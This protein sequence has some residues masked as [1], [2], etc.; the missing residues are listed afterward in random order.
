MQLKDVNWTVFG[1]SIGCAFVLAVLYAALVRWT[2]RRGMEGQTAWA[3]VI[4]VTFTLLAMIPFFG[5][6]AV[7]F[8]FCYFIATGIPMIV[9]YLQRVQAEMQEDKKQANQIAK[10]FLNDSKATNRQEHI[11]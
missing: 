4:G 9:E 3:V 7:A 8:M 6:N 5:L 10:D 11:Q 1:W 2:S